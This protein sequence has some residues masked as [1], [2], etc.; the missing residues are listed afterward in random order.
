MQ[1]HVGCKFFRYFG[2][3]YEM[4]R[5]IRIKNQDTYVLKDSK[6]ERLK[7]TKRELQDDYVKLTPDGAIT[8]S[9]VTLQNHKRDVV[10]TVHRTKDIEQ[11]DDTP[12]V[13]CRQSIYDLFT[14][15][16]NHDAD[17]Q[18]I[19]MSISR[20]TCPPDIDFRECSA[21]ESVVKCQLIDIYMDDKFDDILSLLDHNQ[22]DEV[23]AE[24]SKIQT[25]KILG[26]TSNLKDLMISTK[27]M[28]DFLRAFDIY[29]LNF[30]ITVQDDNT[31]PVEQIEQIEDTIKAKIEKIM[32]LPY[33]KDIDLD[34]IQQDYILVSDAIQEI[35]VVAMI[36]GEYINRPYE[37]LEDHRDRDAMINIIKNRSPV[38]VGEESSSV[39][40]FLISKQLNR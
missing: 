14:N 21:C 15:L 8:L 26:W 23:L 40:P 1:P 32:V 7:V 31:L 16:T 39:K 18:Y 12:W 19:G 35:Y 10:I 38:F 4:Y 13:I 30:K 17:V 27:F 6:G 2:D 37:Q 28:Y 9:V 11:G 29:P 20:E 22:A 5:L 34:E 24:M 3:E 33:K 36:K 25:D